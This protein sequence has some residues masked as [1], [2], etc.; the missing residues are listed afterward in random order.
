MISVMIA[1][2]EPKIRQ[3][4]I[5]L[6]EWEQMELT[7]TA[8]VPDG[9][10]LLEIL[11]KVPTEIALIDMKMPG[12]SG[13]RLIHWLAR[14]YPALKLVV[15][16]G[17]DDFEYTKA[18]INANVMGYLLKPVDP[19]ELKQVL[20]KCIHALET[21]KQEKKQAAQQKMA[22]KLYDTLLI[23]TR[24]WR[25]LEFDSPSTCRQELQSCLEPE[26]WNE[27][28][29]WKDFC[30]RLVIL[31]LET[32]L[33]QETPSEDAG[34]HWTMYSIQN[35]LEEL[36]S[37][38]GK[39]FCHSDSQ[40]AALFLYRSLPRK[41][42]EEKL[43]AGILYIRRFC[44]M[45]VYAGVSGTAAEPERL[46]QLYTEAL[47]AVMNHNLLLEDPVSW[48]QE[49]REP[50]PK[51]VLENYLPIISEAASSPLPLALQ[52][53]MRTYRQLMEETALSLRDLLTFNQAA[54]SLLISTGKPLNAPSI[55]RQL[56]ALQKEA[57][58]EL[59]PARICALL[60]SFL[61][62]NEELLMSDN[63]SKLAHQ[64]KKDI[65]R[66]LHQNISIDDLAKTCHFSKTY[67]S[68]VFKQEFHISPHQYLLER[69]VEKAKILLM[70]PDI[71]A[72]E[73]VALL[74]FTDES[75]FSKVFKRL[76]GV[77]PKQY[78]MDHR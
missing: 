24:F 12:V 16:S 61:H 36:F 13:S 70:N 74:G 27:L 47:D 51:Q 68:R 54:F 6:I 46:H 64:L 40:T 53:V 32:A 4:L 43:N 49:T 1:D 75:H 17:Y 78:R 65:D 31:K 20:G 15:I 3:N 42:L 55:T 10:S 62:R 67:L 33:I 44:Q 18:A 35:I 28:T 60:T 29:E 23:N 7:L 59:S 25:L 52:I 63:E 71:K 37:D 56:Y 57:L 8:E 34:M 19:D 73:I 45:I 77:S 69:K 30:G 58:H 48:Y 21:E 22:L 39:V 2:D 72:S 14:E 9:D 41:E 38:C 76:T 5:D 66:N 26:P 50:V 11:R